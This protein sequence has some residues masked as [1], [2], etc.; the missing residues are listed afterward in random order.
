MQRGG[1][2]STLTS[3]TDASGQLLFTLARPAAVNGQGSLINLNL[4]A[5]AATEQTRLQLLNSAAVGTEG[6][7]ATLAP[8]TPHLL[9]ITP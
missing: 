1:A 3:R 2:Q 8:L 4:R 9:R 5:N 7:S 6:R